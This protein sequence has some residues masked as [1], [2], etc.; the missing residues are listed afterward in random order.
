[1]FT[2]PLQVCQV[3]LGFYALIIIFIASCANILGKAK[4]SIPE[5]V[6]QPQK[7][8]GSGNPADQYIWKADFGGLAYIFS[9][10]FNSEW[11]Y[12]LFSTTITLL[13]I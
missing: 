10:W 13:F 6:L 2:T 1:M 8:P 12:C 7:D 11:L 3:Q 4:R 5:E 9:S